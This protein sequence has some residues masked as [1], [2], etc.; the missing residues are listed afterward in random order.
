MLCE[1]CGK[2]VETTSRVK[3]EGSVLRLC[4]ACSRFGVVL[5]P[6]PAP[7]VQPLS[8]SGGSGVPLATGGTIVRR[9]RSTEERDLF[10][11]IPEM[12]LAEDWSKRIRIAREHLTWTPEELGKR[13][14]EKKS[15]ILKMESGSFRPPDATIR[16][17]ET[18][19]RI[20]LRADAQP[21]A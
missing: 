8:R 6:P 19:L 11:E 1:M 15:V 10:K 3:V 17:I 5:D 20:R 7:S 21:P 4:P 9:P 13:L 14:N 18:L 16:K 12:E 2:D